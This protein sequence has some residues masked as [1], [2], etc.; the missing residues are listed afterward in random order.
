MKR[1]DELLKKI[2]D[3]ANESYDDLDPEEDYGSNITDALMAGYDAGENEGAIFFA[4]ELCE[5]FKLIR[6]E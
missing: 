4:R 1:L 3:K 2:I 6:G 5:E